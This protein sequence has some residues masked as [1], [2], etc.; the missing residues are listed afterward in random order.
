MTWEAIF[1]LMTLVFSV[2]VTIVVTTRK[3]SEIET[4]IREY[5]DNKDKDTRGFLMLAIDRSRTDFSET[6]R[7]VKQHSQDAHERIDAVLV[8]IKN[9]ELY[10]RDKYVSLDYFNLTIARI[11]KTMDLINKKLDELI[12]RG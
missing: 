4:N 10:I 2:L 6:V 3:L 7:A 11:E 5:F 9:V 1:L 12:D 8:D